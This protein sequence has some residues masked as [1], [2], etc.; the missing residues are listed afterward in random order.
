MSGRLPRCPDANRSNH[1]TASTRKWTARKLLRRETVSDGRSSILAGHGVGGSPGW[2]CAHGG[3]VHRRDNGTIYDGDIWFIIHCH[4]FRESGIVE[5]RENIDFE[6]CAGLRI[7]ERTHAAWSADSSKK[8][9]CHRLRVQTTITT[10]SAW[11]QDVSAR[12]LFGQKKHGRFGQKH[13][14]FGQKR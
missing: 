11:L 14:R 6:E 4:W 1:A 12:I 8:C 13:G 10:V 5:L 7:I 3:G 9:H 2:L